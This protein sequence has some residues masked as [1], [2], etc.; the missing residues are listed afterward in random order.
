MFARKRAV[1]QLWIV[2]PKQIIMKP[3][4]ETRRCIGRVA[5][6]GL[7]GVAVSIRTPCGCYS[8]SWRASALYPAG[9]EKGPASTSPS[10]LP[11]W[12]F[13]N[14]SQP[15]RNLTG[16]STINRQK[17]WLINRYWPLLVVECVIVSYNW[18][19]MMNRQQSTIIHHQ[20]QLPRG[21]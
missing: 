8:S 19:L 4:Q 11:A 10:R 18:P 17:L 7:H 9:R 16:I 14:Y 20:L 12:E 3:P 15:R 21:H 6:I 5:V 1:A 13:T 2:L